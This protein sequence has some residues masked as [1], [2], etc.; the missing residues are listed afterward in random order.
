MVA[1]WSLVSGLAPH[2]GGLAAGQ[3]NAVLRRGP[4]AAATKVPTR[5]T[6]L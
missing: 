5:V 4:L 2:I 1:R 6:Y 3:K